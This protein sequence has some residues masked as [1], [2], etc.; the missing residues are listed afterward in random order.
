MLQN[1]QTLLP[2]SSLERPSLASSILPSAAMMRVNFIPGVR[3]RLGWRGMRECPK[4]RTCLTAKIKDMNGVFGFA[5]TSNPE[6]PEAG[7]TRFALCYFPSPDEE[8]FNCFPVEACLIALSED[9]LEKV[10]DFRSHP[11]LMALFQVGTI[12]CTFDPAGGVGLSLHAGTRDRVIAR[13]GYSVQAPEGLRQVVELGGLDKDLPAF[14]IAY[15]FFE[16]LSASL[17][18]STGKA[19]ERLKEVALKN[20]VTS[21]DAQGNLH[22]EPCQDSTRTAFHIGWGNSATCTFD[23]DD[24]YPPVIRWQAPDPFPVSLKNALWWNPSVPG[25]RHSIDKSTMGITER[26]KLI[27]LT[28]FLGAGKTSFLARFIEYQAARNLFVAV[29]QNE[30]GETGLDAKL[31]DQHYAVKEMD[32]GCICCTLV[33]NLGAA[34]QEISSQFQPDFV[35]VETTGLANP[36]NLLAELY[37]LEEVLELSSITCMVDAM[38]AGNQLNNYSILKDQIRLADVVLLNKCDLA[39]ENDLNDLKA[40]LSHLNP[41]AQIKQTKQGDINPLEIYGVNFQGQA[42]PE[43]GHQCSCSAHGLD[44]CKTHQHYGISSQL[45]RAPPNLSKDVLEKAIGRL[46][47]S[48]LRVK[49]IISLDGG[50]LCVCQYVPGSLTLS[51]YLGDEDVERFLVFIGENI[52]E[53]T[54]LFEN[55]ITTAT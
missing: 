48:V 13:D 28:G 8:L 16:I 36:A 37:E 34:L 26:P 35:V 46:P 1:L 55:S 17:T 24:K 50:R 31:L 18:F 19:P 51:D 22:K 52:S 2:P 12:E 21:Y 39:S 32:E 3:Q 44:D 53:T 33:G 15:K 54:A 41:F 23:D 27:V 6:R 20:T 47:S 42:K 45:W 40:K 7:L 43:A 25:A 5:P 4:H 9:Y 14:E 29:V 38:N 11:E 10:R 49:G 30:I